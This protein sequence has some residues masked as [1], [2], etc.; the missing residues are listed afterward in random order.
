MKGDTL[1][2]QAGL[3]HTDQMEHNNSGPRSRSTGHGDHSGC[4]LRSYNVPLE[5]TVAYLW[6]DLGWQGLGR[7][8]SMDRPGHG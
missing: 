4:F 6:D 8:E 7:T 1:V 3:V 5:P 2:A